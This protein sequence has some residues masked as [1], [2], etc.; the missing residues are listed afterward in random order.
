MI[1]NTRQNRLII[2]ALLLL[3]Q[4][5]LGAQLHSTKIEL[6]EDS[7]SATMED[8]IPA[9]RSFF[10][11]F[12]DY[13]NDA[14]KEK[15][16]KK[17]DFSV[18]GGPHYSSDTKFGLGLVAAGLYRTDRIDTLLP[19]SNVSLYGDVS[20]VGFYL[21]GVRGNHLFPKD[22]YRLNYN[23]YFYSFPSLY[24]GRGYDNGANSDNESDYKRF[25][26]QVKVDF[27]FR[28]AKNFYIGPM[29]IF[30]YID[31][32][33]FEKPELWEGMAARTTNTSLGL[34]LLYDSR[35]FLTN[36]YHGYY[37]RIDQRFSP[38][39]LG[40]KYAF[41]STELTTSAGRAIPHIAYLW[42]YP[43]GI[44]GNVGKFLLHARILR[45]TLSGQGSNGRANRTPATRLETEWSSCMGRSGNDFSTTFRVHPET[46]SA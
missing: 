22:K 4:T 6:P 28:L 13:F 31:G 25:Q 15:K 17:F 19:P 20:T 8:P 3:T 34:S 10:K 39:F 37:L 27:M 24:W 30:D 46:H 16:N 2:F 41:S 21:L 43:L 1:M 5:P 14:N 38:A 36:A 35:D 26:A 33:N 18:I 42:R 32:R 44:D 12:L 29:A 40:N 7:I 23:L 9:K 45:R 11:K